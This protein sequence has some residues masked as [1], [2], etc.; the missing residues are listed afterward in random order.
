V[1]VLYV[2]EITGKAGI[3][4]VKHCLPRLKKERDISFVIACADG[5]T[6]GNGLGRN[7]AAYLRKLGID[8]LT[9]GECCF[10]KKDLVENM[11]KLPWVLRP[12]NLN[13]EAPGIGARVF[14]A[15]N[16]K[17]AVAVLLGQSGFIRLH[18]D[19]PYARLPV[20]LERL[21]RETPCIL[22]DFHAE[23]TAEKQTLFA[24][25]DGKCSAVI[26]SHTRVQTA[27]PA[28]L[29]GGTA[30]ITDAGRTGSAE[31]VGGADI[32]SRVQEYL[33]GIP[34]WTR[35]AWR[36]PELQGILVDI[37]RTGA[38]RS[39]EALRVPAPEMPVPPAG[40]GAAREADPE[41]EGDTEEKP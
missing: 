6:G 27:D 13:P 24:L 19:N 40:K 32:E 18:G 11:A 33:T 34:D 20:L 31:S 35:E 25:A 14:R 7:H 39:I 12:E 41:E 9:L 26:G 21:R 29:G 3:H 22:V 1:R 15:G 4:A 16:E 38:A 28:V 37:D 23:A 5:A 8:V 36:R 17:I 10:Y 2:A 30:V